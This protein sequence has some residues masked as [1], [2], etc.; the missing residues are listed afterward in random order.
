MAVSEFSADFFSA[1]DASL[2]QP[3]VADD[4][5]NVGAIV[6][7]AR[8][9]VSDQILEILREEAWIVVMCLKLPE[10]LGFVRGKE[11]ETLVIVTCHVK[12]RV[13]SVE[14]KEDD[15]EGEK[16]NH[17]ALVGLAVEDLWRHVSRSTN[18]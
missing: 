1:G 15:T 7:E 5:N 9:H 6:R 11:L 3:R 16:V 18:S 17:L 14:D 8:E 10:R 13:T 4:V 2:C 12:R